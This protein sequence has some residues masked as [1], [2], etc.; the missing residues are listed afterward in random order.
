MEISYSQDKTYLIDY[1]YAA[2][3]DPL[4]DVMSFL[5]ENQINDPALRERFYA[6]YFNEM[7]DTVRKQLDIWENFQNLL[8]CMLGDDDV[9][10]PT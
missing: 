3:N 4:F 1:E 7:N 6:V 5:S 10:K 8:W 9:G 2:N